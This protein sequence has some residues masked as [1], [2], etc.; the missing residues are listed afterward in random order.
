MS[1]NRFTG[2]IPSEIGGLSMLI[3]LYLYNNSFEG[4]FSL[5]LIDQL[6]IWMRTVT[7]LICFF[8]AFNGYI[9][10]GSTK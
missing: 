7:E 8:I 9:S 3:E 10:I 1:F 6:N 2:S 5:Y 4:M